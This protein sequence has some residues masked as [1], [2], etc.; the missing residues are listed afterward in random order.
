M[1]C[2]GVCHKTIIQNNVKLPNYDIEFHTSGQYGGFEFRI[3][4]QYGA[5]E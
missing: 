4:G 5:F 1:L 3:S 2:L